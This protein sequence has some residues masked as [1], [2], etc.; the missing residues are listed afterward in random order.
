MDNKIIVFPK[1]YKGTAPPTIEQVRENLKDHHF[2]MIEEITDE[3]AAA[4]L[5][6]I[7]SCGI[8]IN[9]QYDIGFIIEAIRSMLMREAGYDNPVQEIADKMV[10]VTNE[11]GQQ[12]FANGH[13][14]G[15]ERS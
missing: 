10:V 13:I 8:H 7:N 5:N 2:E 4:V 12:V 14:L 9:N 11:R 3:G 6:V 1:T 15:T